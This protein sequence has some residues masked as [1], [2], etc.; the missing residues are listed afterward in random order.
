MCYSKIYYDK[1]IFS[2]RHKRQ[3]INRRVRSLWVKLKWTMV[4]APILSFWI[5]NQPRS[6][7]ISPMSEG[8]F[9]NVGCLVTQLGN[10]ICRSWFELRVYEICRS[11]FELKVYKICRSWFDLNRSGHLQFLTKKIDCVLIVKSII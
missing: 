5:I 6:L 8:R 1:I 3:S 10:K 2:I 7:N 11:W 4:R 9:G